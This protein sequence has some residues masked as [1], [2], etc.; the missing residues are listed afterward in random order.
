MNALLEGD[1]AK[2]GVVGIGRAPDL[3]RA[4]KRTARRR[5]RLAPGRTL[6]DRARVPRRRPTGSTPTPRRRRARSTCATA[7][8]AP[9]AVSGAFSVDDAR[10][11]ARA[12]ARARASAACPPAPGHELTGAYGLETRTVSAAINASILPLVERTA[13]VVEEVLDGA[14]IDVPLLVL[15]GDGGSMSLS[16]VPRARRR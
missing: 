8:A 1:V 7:A 13:G 15:R 4:R 2:V 10:D 3:R 6:R 14:G 5:I 11:R 12:V 9:I 16:R